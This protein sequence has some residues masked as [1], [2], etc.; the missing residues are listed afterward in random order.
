MSGRADIS[1]LKA[2]AR[3]QALAAR[4]ALDPRERA[5]RSELAGRRLCGLADAIAR[6]D[7]ARPV[8]AAYRAIRSEADP[9]VLVAHAFEHGMAVA[10][11]CLERAHGALA[12]SMRLVDRGSWSRLDAPF[13]DRP[14]RA[15]RADDAAL[16]QFPVVAPHDIDLVIVPTVA[17]GTKGERL[18]YGGGNYDRYLPL[19]GPTCRVVGFAFAEQRLGRL[20][21]ERHDRALPDIVVA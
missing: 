6:R 12:M 5:R 3:S 11:P 2:R 18:G 19:V 15:L 1:A 10:M 8:I 16:G 21:R 9:A 20:P 17:Y 13:L 4:D 14:A 7:G